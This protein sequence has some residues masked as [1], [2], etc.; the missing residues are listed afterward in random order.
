M[1]SRV[2]IQQYISCL[3]RS[4]YVRFVI[5]S[6]RQTSKKK[7]NYSTLLLVFNQLTIPRI[8]EGINELIQ[9][10]SDIKFNIS[11]SISWNDLLS[12]SNDFS[13]EYRSEMNRKIQSIHYS[14]IKNPATNY[15]RPEFSSQ[16]MLLNEP[17]QEL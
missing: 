17:S 8:W 12:S 15:N 7:R 10:N 5:E 1:L 6:L 2:N 16:N 13:F 9:K 14:S 4:V 3:Y 11:K